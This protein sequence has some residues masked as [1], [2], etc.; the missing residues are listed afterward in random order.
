[1]R[2]ARVLAGVAVLVLVV[3]ACTIGRS[4]VAG[5]LRPRPPTS[6]TPV[7]TPAPPASAGADPLCPPQ[8]PPAA[9]PEP[10]STL[11][12]ILSTVAE[13]IQQVRGLRF[14]R[15]VGAEP[16][17]KGRMQ[18]LVGSSFGQS[19]PAD[20]VRRQGEA[21]ITIGALPPGTDLLAALKAF[22]T[23]EVIGFYDNQTKHLVFLGSSDP[24]PFQRFT[25]AHELTHALD[26]QHFDLSR[27]DALTGGCKGDE[28]AAFLAMT[29]GDA[30]QSQY[31]WA[32]Q[33]LSDS[34]ITQLQDEAAA[35]PPPPTGIPDFVRQELEF[36]YTAGQAFIE[37]LMTRGGQA[38]VDAA[39]RNPPRSTEQILHPGRYPG[40][41]P[42]SVTVP[43]LA[44]R[45]G[46]GW[47]AIDRQDV[48]EEDLQTLLGLRLSSDVVAQAATGWDGGQYVAWAGGTHTAVLMKTV[49][50]SPGDAAQ[51]ASA[52]GDWGREDVLDVVRNGTTVAVQFASDPATL[53][54]LH[55]AA[56]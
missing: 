49:W 12:P 30:V 14:E 6:P 31:R 37:A 24:T 19:Y 36:P 28:A 54:A 38:A 29:E 27:I 9:T 5:D 47:E 53:A 46:A 17:T 43:D 22:N 50:D 23:S 51:F 45:L 56:G 4:S 13:Q 25:L 20:R 2:S 42:R 18:R 44:Q 32:S 10:A 8:P 3:S 33:V 48:G 1:M 34:E 41:A 35:F 39:F 11:P 52:M 55:T 16:V 7:S 40:D 21:L 26:D 15:P